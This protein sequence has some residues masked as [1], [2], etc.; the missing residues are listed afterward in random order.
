MAY[1]A[2]SD[3]SLRLERAPPNKRRPS[4]NR[5]LKP[6]G[7]FRM[8]SRSIY[9]RRAILFP[10]AEQTN[11]PHWQSLDPWS[12][13]RADRSSWTK[14]LIAHKSGTPMLRFKGPSASRPLRGVRL[15]T[16]PPPGTKAVSRKLAEGTGV[17]SAPRNRSII[18][19]Y[20]KS[21]T[22]VVRPIWELAA[23]ALQA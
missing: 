17:A 13:R 1:A 23:A 3:Y 6:A 4:D 14:R 10:S 9:R 2:A 12:L 22:L 5:K 18:G 19:F 20:E 21:R 7:E 16:G 8:V 15:V 11:H